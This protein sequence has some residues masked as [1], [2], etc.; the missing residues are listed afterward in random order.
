M[1]IFKN[2][3]S[4]ELVLIDRHECCCFHSWVPVILSFFI[5]ANVVNGLKPL[6]RSS[7]LVTPATQVHCRAT[8]PPDAVQSRRL[9]KPRR[10]SPREL[11]QVQVEEVDSPGHFYISFSNS[12][13]AQAMDNMMLEMRL[14]TC[15]WKL[16]KGHGAV[17]TEVNGSN[18]ICYVGKTGRQNY[19]DHNINDLES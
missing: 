19:K 3:Q 8:V 6:L 1:A 16:Q 4:R 7:A 12:E 9:R 13:E 14:L 5:S 10:L 15:F 17:H 11:V 18:S 2:N